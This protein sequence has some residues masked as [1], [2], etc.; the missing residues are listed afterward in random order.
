MTSSRDKIEVRRPFSLWGTQL[1]LYAMYTSGVTVKELSLR[2][3]GMYGW[4][5]QV[6]IDILI[7]PRIWYAPLRPVKTLELKAFDGKAQI[8]IGGYSKNLTFV[9][10]DAAGNRT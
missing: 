8:P 3:C 4:Y 10:S 9:C 5:S 6:N 7:M 2:D 1:V